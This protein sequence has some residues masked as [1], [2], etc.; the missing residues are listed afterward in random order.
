M[1][2]NI[3]FIGAGNMAASMIGGLIQQGFQAHQIT[4]A[5]IDEAK[6]AQLQQQFQ[7]HTTP[8]NQQAIQ[9][10]NVVIFAV[11]PQSLQIAAKTLAPILTQTQPLILSIAAGIRTQHIGQWLGSPLSIVRCMPNTPALIQL[12]ATGLYANA[13]TSAEEKTLAQS[14]TDAI[15]LSVWVETEQELD[16]VTA[17]SGSGPAYFFLFMEALEQAAQ[18]L[19]LSAQT[20]HQLTQ[21]T[22][23]G[24]A[25]MATQ[26]QTPLVTL[27]KNVTSPGG[28]TEKAILSFEN[29]D[30]RKSVLTA[31]NAAY[32][33]SIELS[34]QF[35]QDE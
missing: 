17:L 8:D 20:A 6:L 21:Q 2:T 18:T 31:V 7:I 4:A 28:T 30:L 34:Q 26:A 32:Q 19:G 1:H 14:I 25:S 24:A 23:L 35:G 9:Q 33:R 16:L 3:T 5:D 10:A 27:R 13:H 29:T 22:A 11:K 12:G 15:G